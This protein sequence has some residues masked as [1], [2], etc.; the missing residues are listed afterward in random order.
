ML[1]GCPGD[2]AVLLQ[3][4]GY[5]GPCGKPSLSL[6]GVDFFFLGGGRGDWGAAPRGTRRVERTR[7][8]VEAG[9]EGVV[10]VLLFPFLAFYHDCS[11]VLDILSP[12]LNVR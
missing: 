8:R 12:T 9:S 1:A 2:G 11:F 3:Q 4:Q 5:I 7:G 10:R 6:V